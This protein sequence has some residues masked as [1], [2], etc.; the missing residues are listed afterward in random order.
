[1][2]ERFCVGNVYHLHS[3]F[4]ALLW[5]WLSQTSFGKHCKEQKSIDIGK[6]TV[7]R[8]GTYFFHLHSCFNGVT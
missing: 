8:V 7:E 5:V 3:M 6:S 1:M 4:D 2:G